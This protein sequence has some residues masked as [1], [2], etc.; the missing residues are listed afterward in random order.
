MKSRVSEREPVVKRVYLVAH[1]SF[2]PCVR[3]ARSQ[4]NFGV[5]ATFQHEGLVQVS[6]GRCAAFSCCTCVHMGYTRLANARR[7]PYMRQGSSR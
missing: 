5:D 1:P 2:H 3:S 4:D 7:T 6:L